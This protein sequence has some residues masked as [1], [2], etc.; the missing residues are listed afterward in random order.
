MSRRADFLQLVQFVLTGHLPRIEGRDLTD[1]LADAQAI[2]EEALPK[3]KLSDAAT[4]YVQWCLRE[5]I[6]QDVDEPAW[7][8]EWHENRDAPKVHIVA[9]ECAIEVVSSYPGIP[10]PDSHFGVSSVGA[11]REMLRKWWVERIPKSLVMFVV[12]MRDEIVVFEK[13]AEVFKH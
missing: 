13:D 7:H 10:D 4:D 2:P 11:F 1:T 12:E 3:E 5:A 6:G 9:N 8:Q